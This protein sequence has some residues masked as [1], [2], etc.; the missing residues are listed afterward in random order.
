M[1]AVATTRM[2]STG[3]VVIPEDVRKKLGLEGGAQFVVV[4]ENGVVILKTVAQPSMP[5]FDGVVRKARSQA[6]AAGM[7]QADVQRATTK[8]RSRT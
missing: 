6:R 5:D 8:V 1:K 7:T 3:K 4:A 2:S